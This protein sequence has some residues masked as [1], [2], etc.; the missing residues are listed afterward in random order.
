MLTLATILDNPGE[1]SQETRYRRHDELRNLGYTGLV[2]YPTTALSG[3]LGA[4]TLA[5]GDVRR[6]VADQ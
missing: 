2:I 5:S 1:P 4:D 6:W 3:L